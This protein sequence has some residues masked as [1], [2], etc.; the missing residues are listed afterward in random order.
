M[1]DF[2]SK[3]EACITAHDSL[4][5]IG[6][7][8]DPTKLPATIASGPDRLFEFSQAIIDATHDLACAFKPNSAF[9]ESAGADGIA[10]LHKICTY[11]H[12]HH[13][14]IPIVL[15]FKRADIGNT[16]EHYARFAFEY[17]GV[18]AVTVNPYLGREAIQPFLD[19]A[20]KGIIVLC[21]TSNPGAGE[22]QDL[23]Y[24]GKKLYQLVAERVATEWNGHNNCLLVVGAT[25]PDELAWVRQTVG[26][27]M[28]LLVPGLGAQGGAVEPTIKA[29]RNAA[30][31][32]MLINSSREILYASGGADFAAG[33][34]A[35]A[36]A[37]R[38][39]I[40]KYR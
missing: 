33:A 32:G 34:R 35:K 25:Y 16:N 11:L 27:D 30:G 29:G 24:G 37:I 8:P 22:F 2:K 3:L 38:D 15:D 9:Y 10:Q 17:L 31:S 26:D 6:L 23:E 20:D 5:C 1:S 39:E 7:D 4:L 12:D 13:P 28:F 21:R 36:Q 14:D 19:Y 18:D 40:N